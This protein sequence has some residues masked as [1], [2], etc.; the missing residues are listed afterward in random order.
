MTSLKRFGQVFLLSFMIA[1]A[2]LV[3]RV[4][5]TGTV[6][7]DAPDLE[8]HI[9]GSFGDWKISP[10]SAVIKPSEEIDEPGTATLYRAYV[11]DAGEMVTLVIAYGSPRGDSVRLHR[12][13][14]C[15]R[16]QGFDVNR[17]SVVKNDK[18][19]VVQLT[20]SRPGRHETISYWMRVGD[21]YAKGQ[22]TQQLANIG[23][24]FGQSADSV[25]VRLS[26]ASNQREYAYDLHNRFLEDFV[27]ALG[28]E[29]RALLL[30]DTDN[31]KANV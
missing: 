3:S 8:A 14:V 13:E 23:A 21:N 5:D 12:P 1:V 29:A 2:C 24:G 17:E 25:L 19:P 4:G 26:V 27:P 10:I 18:V 22:L 20:A 16:A 15:Y 11:N 28:K 6:V 31:G 30:V 7:Y 9:P